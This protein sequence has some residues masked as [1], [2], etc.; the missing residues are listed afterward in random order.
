MHLVF[1]NLEFF[2]FISF[3]AFLSSFLLS[4]LPSSFFLSFSQQNAMF[5]IKSLYIGEQTGLAV[6]WPLRE[7]RNINHWEK[8]MEFHF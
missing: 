7:S 3:P 1:F 5:S 6:L 2:F 8:S 4:F